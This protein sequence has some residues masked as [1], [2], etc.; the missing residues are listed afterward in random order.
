MENQRMNAETEYLVR[1]EG[2]IAYQSEGDGP[3][4]VLVPGMGDLR[5][6]YRFLTPALVSSG[7]RV[8]AVDLRGHGDSDVTFSK[9]GDASTAEDLAA[10]LKEL[11]PAVLIG[12]SMAAGAAVIVAAE[13]PG[14]V[15]GL[16]LIGPFVRQAASD[17][18][19]TRVAFRIL[20][21]RPWA[22]AVWNAYLPKLY[23]GRLPADF[24][25]YRARVAASMR[26]PGYARAFSLTTRT[27]HLQAANSLGRVHTPALVVMGEKDP[28]FKNPRDEAAWIA[29]A[30]TART[31]MIPEAGHYPQSQQPELVA[32]AISAFL[33][34]VSDLA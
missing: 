9:Y 6:A 29:K 7:Y 24:D 19:M 18:V 4:V 16:V 27:D 30:L 11:G 34:E 32:E 12:N 22:A 26:R 25:K 28:D 31:V 10:L 5:S 1:P 8:V 13:H 33:A 23:A 3:L 15:N 20:M 14:L 17:S 2:R 21:A